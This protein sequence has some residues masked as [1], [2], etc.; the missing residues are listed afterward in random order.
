[1]AGH[2]LDNVRGDRFDQVSVMGNEG[3]RSRIGGKCIFET[4][5]RSDVQM[6][7]RLVQKNEIGGHQKHPRQCQTAFFTAG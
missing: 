3:Q 2:H 4:F 1:M 6:I 5:P 7:G